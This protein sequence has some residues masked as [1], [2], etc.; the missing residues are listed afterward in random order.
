M[1]NKKI[2]PLLATIAIVIITLT[3]GVFAGEAPTLAISRNS[4]ELKNAVF[5]NFKVSSENI[6]DISAIELLVWNEPQ[7][8]YAKGTEISSLSSIR[9]E[10][11]TGY[12]VFQYNDISAKEMTDT[13]YVCAYANINE[14]D[15]YSKPVK[16][17]IFQYAYNNL[18]SSSASEELKTLLTYMLEYGASAQIYFD[19]NTDFLAT[20]EVAKVKVVNGKHDDG[21]STGYFKAGTEI[22]ITANEP[23]EGYEFACWKDVNENIVST[24]SVFVISECETNTYTAEYAEAPGDD[25]SDNQPSEDDLTGVAYRYREKEYTNSETELSAPWILEN[26]KTE[27]N[28]GSYACVRILANAYGEDSPS[29]YD[30]NQADRWKAEN[31]SKYCF[32]GGK[33]LVTEYIKKTGSGSGADYYY[34]DNSNT[35]DYTIYVPSGRHFWEFEYCT[36]KTPYEVYC[37]YKWGEW[38]DWS[39]TAIEETD[40]IDVECQTV[41]KHKVTFELFG[42]T[43]TTEIMVY[44]GNKL[45]QPEDPAKD[46]YSFWGWYKNSGFTEE[47]DFESDVVTENITIYANWLP[48]Q[49]D[50]IYHANGGSF[51]T[52]NNIKYHDT[53]L[54]LEEGL[55]TRTG[56]TFLG[57][58]TQKDGE[59]MYQPGG[60]YS[61][62]ADAELYAVWK[63]DLVDS[64]TC[65]DTMSWEYYY[66]GSLIISGSGDMS[67]KPWRDNYSDQITKVTI[68][69]GVTSISEYAFYSCSRIT[70]I[71]IPDSVSK[72]G[73]NAF[74]ECIKLKEIVIPEGVTTFESSLFNGCS[75]LASIKISENVTRIE[76]GAFRNCSSLKSITIPD[77]VTYIGYHILGGCT[78][79]EELTVPFIGEKRGGTDY[80]WNVL[81]Y[82]FESSMSSRDGYTLQYY[83]SSYSNYFE[84]PKTLKRV[85]VTVDPVIPYGAFYNCYYLDSVTIPDCTTT[86]SN[87]AFY[88]SGIDS[89]TIPESVNSIGDETF[90]GCYTTICGVSGSYAETYA[91]ENNVT[92][93][94]IET[95][96]ESNV[97]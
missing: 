76:H 93:V 86:I 51:S 29:G 90:D 15:I 19:Y 38:S 63:P 4:L 16:F 34:T 65:G 68:N 54:V 78:N 31:N 9:T 81:G 17:S 62:N 79:L 89:I 71:Q 18:N 10:E 69:S 30:T 87:K 57:W 94:P 40:E 58:S 59:V 43:G 36:S 35:V 52:Y 5:M 73:S 97:N 75:S 83:T 96:S 44:S 20:D 26:I 45:S 70:E 6:E 28:H 82:F 85:V 88:N 11:D 56:Y 84:I 32:H 37:Y 91:N 24:D 74:G 50:V 39:D 72:I 21:F 66:D 1:N 77:S 27:Y 41:S 64:G 48:N 67:E 8:E 42:G 49:Y 61:E 12:H 33:T 23:D 2:L 13:I 55:P 92:F 14:Q 95:T 46:G 53:D 22:I 60:I 7:T 80:G 3:V 47:W 25:S